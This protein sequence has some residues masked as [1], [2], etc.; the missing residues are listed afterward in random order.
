MS[1]IIYRC[2]LT[3]LIPAPQSP[4]DYTQQWNHSL[5]DV[6]HWQKLLITKPAH[7]KV[8]LNITRNLKN[9]FQHY[10][11]LKEDQ[12]EY[13]LDSAIGS[14]QSMEFLNF[15]GE[16]E[17]Y[18]FKKSYFNVPVQM[19]SINPIDS[20]WFLI[21]INLSKTKQQK[22]VQG[23]IIDFQKH[24]PIGLL[25]YGPGLEINTLYLQT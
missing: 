25:L 2:P 4:A 17:F 21:H 6:W 20:E 8:E 14:G 1:K 15:P 13:F 10:F 5:I 16:M 12:G 24:L 19:K 3:G 23:D 18:H 7:L 22:I 11:K 9:Q